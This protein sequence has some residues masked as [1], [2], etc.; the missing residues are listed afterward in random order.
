MTT[1]TH[2]TE[3]T[4]AEICTGCPLAECIGFESKRCALWRGWRV[5]MKGKERQR[6]AMRKVETLPRWAYGLE[7]NGDSSG[8][9]R[10]AA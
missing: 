5:Y 10:V 2:W 4:R 8:A 9:V 1:V 6:L 7:G 3:A